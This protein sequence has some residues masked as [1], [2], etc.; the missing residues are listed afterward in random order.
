M[1]KLLAIVLSSPEMAGR[2]EREVYQR[3][4]ALEQYVCQCAIPRFWRASR[5]TSGDA[6]KPVLNDIIRPG[7]F[8]GK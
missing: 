8:A 3:I 4:T 5:T 2:S 7:T 1:R 6:A